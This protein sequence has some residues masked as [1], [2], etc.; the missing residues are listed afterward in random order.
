[1]GGIKCLVI[2]SG[3]REASI[4]E[5]I[6]EDGG[7]I[8]YAY[9]GHENPG[10]ISATKFT[11]GKYIVGDTLNGE[12]IKDF[13][14]KNNIE[15]TII[16]NDNILQA[17]VVDELK[18]ANIP[19]FGA[20]RKGAMIEWSKTYAL[21]II[22]KLAPEMNI[23]SFSVNSEEQLMETLLRYE[24]CEFVIKP[25]GLTAGKGVKVGKVHFKT[26]DEG[27]KYAKKCLI[28][29]GLVIIQDII[30]GKEFTVMGFT[31][32]KTLDLMPITCDYSYRFDNDTGPGTGGMGCFNYSDGK[33]PYLTNSDIKA[34]KDLME[35]VLHEINKDNIEFTGVLYGG[36]FK[37]N[38]GI[39]V[40]E[41][42]ARFG[43][44][45]CINIMGLLDSKFID[46]ARAC[47]DGNLSDNICKYKKDTASVLV[48]IV[49]KGYALN[50]KQEPF[51]FYINQENI[52]K[53]GAKV[54]YSSCIKK[55]NKLIPTGS[56][57]LA[58]I[59]KVGNNLQEVRNDVYELI[60]KNVIGP[61]DYRKDIGYGE[62]RLDFM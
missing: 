6:K 10:I 22:D 35:K 31:D 12:L 36:F 18:K 33:L 13:A 59:I 42:N 53:E 60:S 4:V 40:I 11:G 47:I 14:V 7:S 52:E 32:G 57:R 9:M 15:I 54:I 48:Y 21:E 24:D 8:I 19:T 1:M 49:S 34:C 44:P 43:D 30:E 27:N 2:G 58:G 62:K 55:G 5:K 45:E 41:F 23:K 17:G 20:T 39:K 38:L 51:E 46:V 16:S 61:I 56:S 3:G 25:E 26:K 28:E 50:I 37:S 29:D